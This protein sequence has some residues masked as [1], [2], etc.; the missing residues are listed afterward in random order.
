MT[1][2]EVEYWVSN[3]RKDLFE[4]LDSWKSPYEHN[5]MSSYI[6]NA[7]QDVFTGG[8]YTFNDH[9]F[10]LLYKQVQDNDKIKKLLI[11]YL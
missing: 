9:M 3:P 11:K 5:L 8:N 2:K 10:V 7:M 6:N 1:D 4:C